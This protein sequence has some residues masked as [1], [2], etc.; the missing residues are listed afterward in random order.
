MVFI[1]I[2]EAK[3]SLSRLI[4]MVRKGEDVIIG[5]AG[6]P[7]VKIIPFDQDTRQRTGG[8]WKGKIKISADFDVLPDDIMKTFTLGS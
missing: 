6:K 7:V 3:A 1:N 4:E 5:K 2:S 8:Q